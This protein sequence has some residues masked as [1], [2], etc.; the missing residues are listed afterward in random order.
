MILDAGKYT[1]VAIYNHEDYS[2]ASS[3]VNFEV[4]KAN[5]TITV[6]DVEVEYG[7]NI[8][9]KIE[10]NV[11]SIYTIEIED[12]KT[13]VF[14]NGSR[15]VKIEKTFEPGDYTVKVT[16]QERVKNV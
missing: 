2:F 5:P 12:Y 1:L 6:D 8:I 3:T 4:Y 14:V 11:P 15:S 9:L 7:D 16:S 10:S 13:A